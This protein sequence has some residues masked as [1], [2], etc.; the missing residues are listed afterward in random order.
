M[1]KCSVW[2]LTSKVSNAAIVTSDMAPI[3]AIVSF[4]MTGFE[5]MA[6]NYFILI[7]NVLRQLRVKRV[8]LSAVAYLFFTKHVN[9]KLRMGISAQA[10]RIQYMVWL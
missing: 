5:F 9:S 7:A 4:L 10:L 6:S 3:S 1:M 8:G 2:L